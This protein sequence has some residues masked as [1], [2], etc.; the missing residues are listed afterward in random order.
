MFDDAQQAGGLANVADD[1]ELCA[2]HLPSRLIRGSLQVVIASGGEAPFVVRR[3]RQLL[4]KRFG[5]EWA[6]WMRAAAR[7]RKSV[8]ELKLTSAEQEV[9]FDRFFDETV[10]V[11]ALTTRVPTEAEQAAWLSRPVTSEIGPKGILQ[12]E[13]SD[14]SRSGFVSLVGAGPGDAGLMTVRGRQRLMGAD[15][16]VYDRLAATALP[17]DLPKRVE[18]HCVGKHSGNHPVPQEEINALLIRLAREGKKVVRLKGGDPYMF[19][20]GGEEA[21][22]I[23][24]ADIPY[25]VVPGVTAGVAVPAYAGVPVTHRRDAVRV[26]LV[27]AHES[28]KDEGPSVRWD[29]LAGDSHATLIGYMGVTNLANVVD[30]LLQ[31]GMDAKTPSVVIRYGTTSKH[32]AVYSE[33]SDLPT[34][35]ARA[36]VKPPALFVIGSVVRHAKQLNWFERRPLFGE[37]VVVVSPAREMGAMLEMSGAEVVEVPLPVTAASR[38]V[39][40]A[41][42]L[43]GC[44]L[45]NAVEVDAL[46]EER[47]SLGWGPRMTAWCLSAEAADRA[48][49]QG[50]TRIE[51]VSIL[52]GTGCFLRRGVNRRPAEQ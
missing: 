36:G 18:L 34:A 8:R 22:A 4:E 23:V 24:A 6:E 38:V 2:F 20:R 31:A 32:R 48:R 7:L 13:T 46:A 14:N 50:W 21:Q 9:V 19:G 43:T 28:V 52:E 12:Q 51:E 17:T 3:L 35:V 11:G 44:V 41:L 37:R 49:Q 33:L 39:M 30:R 15:A 26:T 42:P 45:R 25:E 29:L 47:D 1:P 40:G 5:P 10:A 27:T 16:V